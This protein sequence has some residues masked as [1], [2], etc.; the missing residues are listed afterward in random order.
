M[1]WDS[2]PSN[3]FCHLPGAQGLHSRCGQDMCQGR[4]AWDSL[5][6]PAWTNTP[7]SPSGLSP[8][9]GPSGST[10]TSPLFFLPGS[11]GAQLPILAPSDPCRASAALYMLSRSWAHCSLL[12]LQCVPHWGTQ[13]VPSL[14]WGHS[15]KQGTTQHVVKRSFY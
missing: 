11:S 1:V 4:L 9:L 14:L 12:S 6:L 15:L 2:L 7:P 10:H 8:P 3:R 5:W 13:Q